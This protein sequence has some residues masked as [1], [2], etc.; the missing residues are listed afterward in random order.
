MNHLVKIRTKHQCKLESVLKPGLDGRES[1]LLETLLLVGKH[2]KG[3]GC[4]YFR[5]DTN[6]FVTNVSKPFNE[7]KSYA[8]AYKSL[9]G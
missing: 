6:M 2:P 9:E 5:P 4:V 7:Y 1:Y 8:A 3:L